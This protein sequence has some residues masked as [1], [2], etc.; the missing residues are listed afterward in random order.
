MKSAIAIIGVGNYLM[1]DE[2][3][4]IHAIEKLRALSWPDNV[5]I[6]DGGTA[7]VGLLHLIDGRDIAIIIDC[8]D[9]GGAPGEIRIFDPDSLKQDARTESGLHATDLLTALELAKKTVRYPKKVR[10]IGIQPAEIEIGSK[11]SKEVRKSLNWLDK[12]IKRTIVDSA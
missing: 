8:A 12:I 1:G 2:G 5:E 9:F 7:G 6:L 10:I 3:A 11:L 4:G